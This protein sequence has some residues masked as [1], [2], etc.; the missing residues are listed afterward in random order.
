LGGRGGPPIEADIY[1]VEVNCKLIKSKYCGRC[2]YNTEMPLAK[3][4]IETIRSLS[5]PERRFVVWKGGLPRLRNIGGSC[6]FLDKDTNM[7]TIYPYRPIGCRLYPL[8]YVSGEGVTVDRLCPLREQVLKS[9]TE[10]KKR[11]LI[12]FLKRLEEDWGIN[13]RL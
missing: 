2:C 10:E 13:I 5:I 11:L 6:V 7:C 12:S 1:V 8:V 9:I 3:I 4:D